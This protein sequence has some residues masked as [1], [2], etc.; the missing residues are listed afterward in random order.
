M[1][2]GSNFRFTL[3]W[4][5]DTRERISAGEF[6]ERLGNKKSDFIVMAICEYLQRHPEIMAP[7]A[8]I[9]IAT[10]PVF[11]KE[12][13]LSEVK[14]MIRDYMEKMMPSMPAAGESG[15]SSGPSDDDLN[16]MLD[17]LNVFEQ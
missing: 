9:K 6:L 14:D 5:S 2:K 1:R 4:G 7:E 12:Q 11:S 13:V 17:N 3:Q 8:K 16:D 10:Q 15:L